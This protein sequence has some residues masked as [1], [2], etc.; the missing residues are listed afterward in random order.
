MSLSAS[1]SGSSRHPGR[2]SS[3][4]SPAGE[5]PGVQDRGAHRGDD[6]AHALGDVAVS[7]QADGAA[8]D[9]ANR[10][11]QLRIRRP[12]GSPAH[13]GVQRRQPAQ[14]RQHQ[15]HRALGHR[16]GV[17]AGHVGDRDPAI[18][19]GRDVDRVHPGAELVHKS[20]P[21]AEPQVVTRQRPQH[22]PNHLRV[23]QFSIKRPVVLLRAP[24]D[25]EPTRLGRDEVEH[26]R[27]GSEVGENLQ[28]HRLAIHLAM[29]SACSLRAPGVVK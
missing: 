26:L 7:D 1:S 15:Q 18:G 11:A 23:G 27:T 12:A 21:L 4:V 14:R 25:V 6:P 9:L 13:R 24:T 2:P 19:G 3:R 17:G 28:R 8:A 16:G 22:M 20:Q 5:V 29:T 10:L